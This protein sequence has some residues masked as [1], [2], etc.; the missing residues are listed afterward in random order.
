MGLLLALILGSIVY[1]KFIHKAIFISFPLHNANEYENFTTELQE[2]LPEFRVYSGFFKP[3]IPLK[4]CGVLL[5]FCCLQFSFTR[6]ITMLCSIIPLAAKMRAA[7]LPVCLILAL[8]LLRIIQLNDFEIT[9]DG[10]T[11]YLSENSQEIPSVDYLANLIP[12]KSRELT[13]PGTLYV[14]APFAIV[15]LLKRRFIG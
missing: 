1:A 10:R 5:G 7:L 8:I 9:L 6:L 4:I 15:Y 3:L 2:R 11:I 12:K 14:S 13:L